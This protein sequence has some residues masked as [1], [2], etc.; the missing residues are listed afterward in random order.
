MNNPKH[1]FDQ[2]LCKKEKFLWNQTKNLWIK[3]NDNSGSHKCVCR[4]EEKKNLEDDG[5]IYKR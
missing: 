5:R 3:G 1:V 2:I 4:F